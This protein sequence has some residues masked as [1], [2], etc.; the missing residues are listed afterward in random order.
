VVFNQDDTDVSDT[1]A[2]IPGKAQSEGKKDKIIQAPQKN[3]TGVDQPK[4]E[5]CEDKQH[6]EKKLT[7]HQSP[8]SSNSILN[9]LIR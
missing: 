5:R 9:S 6:P 7:P 1:T 3:N 8:K 2:I 4:N